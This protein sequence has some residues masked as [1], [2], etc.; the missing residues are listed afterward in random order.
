MDDQD[1]APVPG[2]WELRRAVAL[3]GGILVLLLL[4]IAVNSCRNSQQ[5]N[6][7]KDYN[8]ELSTIA[9]ES[10]HRPGRSQG[11]R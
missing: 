1:Y 4:I 11:H 8:R 6:A 9:A 5:E 3:V 2:I 10:S 7:L